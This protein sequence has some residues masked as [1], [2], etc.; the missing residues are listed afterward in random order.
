MTIFRNFFFV[1]I[2][3]GVITRLS[4]HFFYKWISPKVLALQISSVFTGII[5]SM[6]AVKIAGFDVAISEYVTSFLIFY[7]F[8]LSRVKS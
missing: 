2:L 7:I 4:N 5:V 6:L 1:V 8:D 3:V